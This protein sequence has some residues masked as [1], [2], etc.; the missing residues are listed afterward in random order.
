MEYSLSVFENSEYLKKKI[1][2]CF[3]LNKS[4]LS[5]FDFNYDFTYQLIFQKMMKNYITVHKM[6]EY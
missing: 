5:N 2:A 4:V 3:I 6:P 1:Y